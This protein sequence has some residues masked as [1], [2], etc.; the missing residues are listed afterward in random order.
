MAI[1]LNISARVMRVDIENV[2]SIHI[3]FSCPTPAVGDPIC[4]GTPWAVT[5]IHSQSMYSSPSLGNFNFH[6]V[7][8]VL[9]GF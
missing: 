2:R 1:G 9:M 5:S 6:N 8:E 3:L 4:G 7:A